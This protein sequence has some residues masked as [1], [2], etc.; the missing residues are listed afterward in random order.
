[1]LDQWG[2]RKVSHPS[3]RS[4]I[5]VPFGLGLRAVRNEAGLTY[6]DPGKRVKSRI[7][8][9]PER[10]HRSELCCRPKHDRPGRSKDSLP[11][12]EGWVVRH[13]SYNPGGIDHYMRYHQD[14]TYVTGFTLSWNNTNGNVAG[15]RI[16]ILMSA[17]LWSHMT[18]AAFVEPA[19]PGTKG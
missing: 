15:E 16:A 9:R 3:R 5:W 1:M 12:H 4:V 19:D 8:D 18:G 14:G 13:L 17:S 7:H 2:F 10:R 6:V 11:G